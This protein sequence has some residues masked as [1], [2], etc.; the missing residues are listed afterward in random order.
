MNLMRGL[1]EIR[2]KKGLT[3][4]QVE[5]LTGISG[6]TISRYERGVISPTAET[7][8]KIAN[9]LEVTIDELL[10]GV[11][12]Q[13]W[14]LRLLVTRGETT[15]KGVIDL[16]GKTVTST[17]ELGDLAMGITL[18]ASYDLWE[19]DDKF[20]GLIEQLR[21]KRATGLKTRKEGW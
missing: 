17:L 19:D 15:G 11:S 9:A 1:R 10:N 5:A 13:D 21:K 18:S 20:E 16:T 7:L 3:L 2:E 4:Q 12:K 8:S 6:N 14:E